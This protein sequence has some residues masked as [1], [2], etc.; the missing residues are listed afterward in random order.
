MPSKTLISIPTYDEAENVE[1]MCRQLIDLQLDADLLFIDDNS[2]D[3][4]GKI[5]D[6]LA[7]EFDQLTVIHRPGKEGIGAAHQT[8]IRFA[9]EQGYE[10]L[11]TLDCDFTH[12]PSDIPRFLEASDGYDT[13]VGSRHMHDDSLPGWNL[14]RRTL[15]K[16]A[17]LLTS[18]VLGMEYDATGAFRLYNL[19]TIPHRAFMKVHSLDYAFFVESLFI[20]HKQGFKINEI[21]IVLPVRTY[22]HSKMKLTNVR[23]SVSQIFSLC[24]MSQ[25][26]PTRFQLGTPIGDIDPTWS[27]PNSGT[28]I[29]KLKVSQTTQSTKLSRPAIAIK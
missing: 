3:G 5:L 4:T 10:Q 8:G 15:T 25:V 23:R 7:Q 16:A 9:Y 21:P 14:M 17:H 6:G 1:P 20:L 18:T 28:I 19:K 12:S 13:V 26:H 27:T 11:V 29:G 22:G 24:L 2:P